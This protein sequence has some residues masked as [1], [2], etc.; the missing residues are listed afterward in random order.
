MTKLW[1]FTTL[2][3]PAFPTALKPEGQPETRPQELF[4]SFL[5]MH[6]A[7]NMHVDFQIFQEY[8]GT[9]QSPYYSKHFNPQPPPPRTSFLISLLFA[10]FS[11]APD[12]TNMFA[13]KLFLT[14]A[15][16]QPAHLW[17]NS[18]LGERPL[19]PLTS[20]R[21]PSNRSKQLY[22]PEHK[23]SF[24]PSLYQECRWLSSKMLLS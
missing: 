17:D 20:F 9:L 24:A 4:R 15:P 18:E 19:S 5:N 2:P 8:V 23:V 10:L 6:P 22:I 7:L 21:E 11:L 1:Q 13:F 16:R 12:Y 14:I 3:Q